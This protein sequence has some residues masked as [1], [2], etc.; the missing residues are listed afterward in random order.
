MKKDVI[1]L[2]EYRAFEFR[3][4]N[5]LDPVEPIYIKQVLRRLNILTQYQPLSDNFSA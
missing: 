2:L 5:G 1:S 3:R 4:E